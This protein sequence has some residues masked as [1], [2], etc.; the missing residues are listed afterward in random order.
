MIHENKQ[1]IVKPKDKRVVD[2]LSK[3]DHRAL[4]ALIKGYGKLEHASILSGVHRKTL[5][6][7]AIRG[8]GLKEKLD[9]IRTKLL[10]DSV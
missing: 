9:I 2:K 10:N 6:R 1:K 8:S 5:E 4:K 7:I 3:E